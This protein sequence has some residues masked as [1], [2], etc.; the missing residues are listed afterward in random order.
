MFYVQNLV[1]N[2]NLFFLPAFRVLPLPSPQR[3]P[4]LLHLLPRR[5][6]IREVPRSVPPTTGEYIEG[7]MMIRLDCV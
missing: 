7:Q 1:Q 6:G 2:L 5:P 3:D 4:L